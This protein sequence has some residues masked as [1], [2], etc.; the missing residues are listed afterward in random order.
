M[1][2]VYQ[3]QRAC[4]SNE[5]SL[6]EQSKLKSSRLLQ[7]SPFL[8]SKG[9]IRVG[10]RLKH[11]ELSYSAKHPLLL[12]KNSHFTLTLIDYYHRSYLHA[13]PRTLRALL[14]R[15]F[16]ILSAHSVIRKRIRFCQVCSRFSSTTPSPIMADLPSSRVTP[17]RPFMHCG[18]D[19][20]GPFQIKESSRRNARH[21]KAYFA[22][23]I[24]MATKAI[25]LEALTSLSTE[26][27]LATLSR[28]VA[29]RSLPTDMY[30][31]NGTNF[32]GADRQISEIV[33]F[34]R[35]KNN[36]EVVQT[37]LNHRGIK[38]HFACP[39]APF[40]GGLYESNIKNVKFHLNRVVGNHTLT[41][42]EFITVL[43]RV[44]AV[45]NS[46]PLCEIS[47]SP[48]ELE[49]LTPGH[50]L[51]GGPLLDVPEPQLM[52]VTLNRL[53]R[54]QMVSRMVQ[55]FW[56]RWSNEYLLSLQQRAKWFSPD[57]E[58]L[59]V[60]QLVWI[61]EDGVAPLNY[62]LGKI[63]EVLPNSNDGI[64][65]IVNVR[66]ATGVLRRPVR[67]LAPLILS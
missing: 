16:W 36:Q 28:F 30:C 32:R 12:P 59:K 51:T 2:C 21:Y 57:S 54:W 67:R 14:Q 56:Q 23:F 53:N 64:V 44:E 61:K 39:K 47:P 45:L 9:L 41:L 48:D 7:L 24:C 18:V 62:P 15:S 8:D 27:F 10:G 49:A 60:G 29:R 52:D 43:S 22:L 46:R 17:A 25:H 33:T 4:F 37:A 13:G 55:H 31:D 11:S 1:S 38:F 66:T 63:E 50:F 42:E 58:N 3:V 5:V 19:L 20:A 40:M 34:I 6:L 35:A 65:R 26:A